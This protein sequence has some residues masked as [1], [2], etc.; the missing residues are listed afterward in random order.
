M[1]DQKTL[2]QLQQE[3]SQLAARVGFRAYQMYTFDQE[4]EGLCQ[5]M[6]EVDVQAGKLKA[7]QDAAAAKPPVAIVPDA[8]LPAETI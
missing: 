3:F 2:E 4:V 1:D 5:N 8:I 7:E 6:K